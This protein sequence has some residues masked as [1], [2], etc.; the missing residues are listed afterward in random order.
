[1]MTNIYIN[2]KHYCDQQT[3]GEI[4]HRLGDKEND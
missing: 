1:M 4:R 2:R 3:F